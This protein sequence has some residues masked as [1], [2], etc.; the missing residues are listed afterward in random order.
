M[1]TVDSMRSVM[2]D[3]VLPP[4]CIQVEGDEAATDEPLRLWI[5]S[6]STVGLRNSKASVL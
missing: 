1:D 4:P 2:D 5:V 6:P 3:M